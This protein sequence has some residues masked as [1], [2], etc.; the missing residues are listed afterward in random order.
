MRATRKPLPSAPVVDMTDWP[1]LTMR[2]CVHR[3]LDL[4]QRLVQA[5]QGGGSTTF[6]WSV[7]DNLLEK[8]A[9]VA[10]FVRHRSGKSPHAFVSMPTTLLKH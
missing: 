3:G 7:N 8:K 6:P 2:R 9:W 4:T 1:R 5:G 10:G